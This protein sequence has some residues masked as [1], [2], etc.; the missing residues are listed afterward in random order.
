[1]FVTVTW[2]HSTQIHKSSNAIFS[3][4]SHTVIL[5]HL[6][7][8]T[9]KDLQILQFFFHTYMVWWL[10]Y[11]LA[12]REIVVWL[13]VGEENISSLKLPD[14]SANPVCTGAGFP[15]VKRS[16]RGADHSHPSSADVDNAWRYTYS[17][18]YVFIMWCFTNHKHKFI[19]VESFLR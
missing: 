13:T 7:E 12:N 3:C 2:K 10:G 19:L 8:I 1:M 18:S 4:G 15:T 17:P 11:G 14:R 5:H 9:L 6:R 16:E